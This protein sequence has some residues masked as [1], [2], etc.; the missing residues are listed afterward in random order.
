[1]NKELL[2]YFTNEAP[3][4]KSKSKSKSKTLVKGTGVK[5]IKSKKKVLP[6]DKVVYFDL[7]LLNSSDVKALKKRLETNPDDVLNWARK[8]IDSKISMQQL[9]QAV[10]EAEERINNKGKTAEE[11][12]TRMKF[13][14]KANPLPFGF[15]FDYIDP[16]ITIDPS[17]TKFETRADLL[18]WI[19]NSGP[20]FLFPPTPYTFHSHDNMVFSQGKNFTDK[21]EDPSP[22]KDLEIALFSDFGTGYYHSKYIAKQL[23]EGKYP[24]AIHLGDVYYGG[25]QKEFDDYFI[26]E[27][28]PILDTTSLFTL[29]SNHEMFAG[30][31]P[32]FKYLVKRIN[33]R[34][35]LQRGSYFCIR[36][37]KFQIIGIDTDYHEASRYNDQKLRD[38]LQTRL[39]EGR[40]LNLINILISANEPYEHNKENTSD[41]LNDL[42]KFVVTDKRV[43]LWFWG[44]VHYC[45]LYDRSKK[46]PFI[47]SCIGHG[48]YP[49]YTQDASE[50]YKC[51]VRVRFL[52]TK[53]RFW[54][55]PQ[56]RQ[57]VGNNG[58][59]IMKLKHDGTIEL[60][61][62]DWMK[63]LRC[64]ATLGLDTNKELQIMNIQKFDE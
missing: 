7:P 11:I 62:L 30:S 26:K 21:I 6:Q 4:S 38:W 40:G 63:N 50:D 60:N 28:D 36:N 19:I 54:K 59:C 18:G 44:N 57:D 16:Q 56:M 15:T 3:K 39:I 33:R 64:K 32:F 22:Q 53:S 8:A 48:G 35:Q 42:R 23:K 45:A 49:Y 9:R 25:K 58:Y 27:L 13:M 24:Y 5:S 14:K 1:M 2:K 31:F 41:L 46:L 55:W 10:Y 29:N 47:G 61:Y 43:D 17:E 37:S 51:P 20:N 52:E 34:N 12:K